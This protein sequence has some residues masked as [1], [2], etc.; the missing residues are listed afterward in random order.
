MHSLVLVIADETT[1]SLEGSE[2]FVAHLMEP[3]NE[4]LQ[5]PPYEE[6]VASKDQLSDFWGL[7]HLVQEGDLPEKDSYTAEEIVEAYNKRYEDEEFPHY[8][9]SDGDI[10]QATTANPAGH[11]DWYQVGGRWAGQ[12]RIHPGR[13]I[14][15]D[16][17]DRTYSLGE[18]SWA[19]EG[20]DIP[21]D[22][23]DTAFVADVD[24]LGQYQEGYD[25]A[26][27]YYRRYSDAIRPYWPVLGWRQY[28]AKAEAEGKTADQARVEYQLYAKPSSTAL[29]DAGLSDGWGADPVTHCGEP[30]SEERA[31]LIA[32]RTGLMMA[33]PSNVV[34]ESDGWHQS[35]AG[36]W[37][38]AE[39]D[40]EKD[41]RFGEEMWS[42]ILDLPPT[43]RIWAVDAHS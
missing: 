19:N 8:V 11:W 6:V 2:G 17:A 29:D 43:A 42:R 13:A 16:D 33:I 22:R 30:D 41:M 9:N 37:S 26:I 15:D 1:V 5:V 34:F 18:R 39:E 40:R 23:A 28:L 10:C 12:L 7:R 25:A 38:S 27:D 3:Y 4:N 32:H 14:F 36:L 20:E 35:D 24:F 31:K 21:R